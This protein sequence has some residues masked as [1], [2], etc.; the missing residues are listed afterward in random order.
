[1]K[2]VLAALPGDSLDSG[3]LKDFG[4]KSFRGRKILLGA[5]DDVEA[6]EL[7]V[8]VQNESQQDL[9]QE[10]VRPGQ[11]DFVLTELL[12]DVNQVRLPL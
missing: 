1:M 4:F 2:E 11:E 3:R 6:F 7:R 12:S 8:A 9:A 5:N 10:A